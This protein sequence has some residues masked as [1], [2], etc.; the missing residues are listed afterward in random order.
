MMELKY[1]H[2]DAPYC[3]IRA[4]CWSLAFCLLEC[5]C[6]LSQAGMHNMHKLGKSTG[7]YHDLLMP[8]SLQRFAVSADQWGALLASCSSYSD[9]SCLAAVWPSQFPYHSII[10]AANA[11]MV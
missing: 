4:A 2:N 1:I 8:E 11:Y 6:H 3:Q 5:L 9:I 7:A 10:D